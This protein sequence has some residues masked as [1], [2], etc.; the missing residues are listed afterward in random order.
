[1]YG[2]LRLKRA[3]AAL[4]TLLGASL[5]IGLCLLLLRAGAPDTV[6]LGDRNFPLRAEADSDVEAF[7]R[8]CGCEPQRCVGDRAITVPKHWNAVYTAYN[9]LQ[10]AQGLTLVPYKGREARELIYTLADS[11]DCATV[12]VCDGRIIAA[13]RS[14]MRRG[15]ELKPLIGR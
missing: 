9:D 1:M 8:A 13:H 11:D 14:T 6:A 12:L 15:D 3:R 10:A 4:L 5:L 7:L 2:S